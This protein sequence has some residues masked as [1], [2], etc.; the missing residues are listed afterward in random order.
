MH[1]RVE[2][3][4]KVLDNADVVCTAEQAGAAVRRLADEIAQ[5]LG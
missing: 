3:L 5:R 4:W 2:P 1:D